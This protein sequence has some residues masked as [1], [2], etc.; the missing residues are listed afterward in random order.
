MGRKNRKTLSEILFVWRCLAV[1]LAT[2]CFSARSAAFDPTS[3]ASGIGGALGAVDEGIDVGFALTDLL[4]ELEVSPES[5]EEV[6]RATKELEKLRDR[7]GELNSNREEINDLLQTDLSTAKSLSD[8]LRAVKN[9]I[10]ASKR[11]AEIM[12]LRPKAGTAATQIQQL[13]INSMILDELQAIRRQMFLAQLEERQ[14]KV[15]RELLLNEIN[16]AERGKNSVAPLDLREPSGL[17]EKGVA[18]D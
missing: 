3:I 2:T 18:Y 11:I 7:A 16:K 12:G 10:T 5:E 1:V 13:K 15:R 4:G 6:G 17:H 9:M 8:K 14:N